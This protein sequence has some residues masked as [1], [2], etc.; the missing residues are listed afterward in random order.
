MKI[1]SSRRAENRKNQAAQKLV[2]F[3]CQHEWFALP[4]HLVRK[5]APMERVYG[6]SGNG[7]MG[8][9]HFEN[10]EIPVIDISH[11]I[12]G[13]AYRSTFDSTEM[14]LLIVQSSSGELVGLPIGFQ[15]VL[16]RVPDNAF[17]PLPPSYSAKGNLTCVRAIAVLGDDHPS[18]LL[19]DL[20]TLI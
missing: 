19:L 17:A 10:Q 8:L 2:T 7:T 1:L 13:E 3:Q 18:L 16:R 11:R 6:T 9:T 20:D 14:Y 4:I 15:P 12:F 5:F